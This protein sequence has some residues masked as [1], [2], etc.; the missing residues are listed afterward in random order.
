MSDSTS[1]KPLSAKTK[2]LFVQEFE[3]DLNFLNLFFLLINKS[4]PIKKIDLL[5]AQDGP[6]GRA[7]LRR[8]MGTGEALSSPCA[9]LLSEAAGGGSDPCFCELVNDFGRHEADSC[10]VSDK[11]AE[12]RVRRT[13]RAEVYRCHAGLVDIAVPVICDGEH[14]ATLLTGQVLRDLPSARG[15]VQIARDVQHLSYLNPE[16]LEKAYYRVPVVSDADIQNAI[17][18]LEVFAEYLAN[19]WS[20]LS[21]VVRDQRRAGV[22]SQLLRKEFAHA[23]LEGTVPIREELRELMHNIGLTRFPNRVLVVRLE[24][25]DEYT[26]PKPSFDVAFTAALQAVEESCDRR[27][28]RPGAV[29]IDASSGGPDLSSVAFEDASGAKVLE[30]VNSS[31]MRRRF[32]IRDGGGAADA[33]LPGLSIGTFIWNSIGVRK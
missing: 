14:I 29:R 5:W 8:L 23:V 24:S 12:Q 2:R 6:V 31:K 17:S 32:T 26:R 7:G 25:E 21:Q 19:S 28:V 18:V 9:K 3:K 27:F 10:G 1:T 22:E 15:F 16:A 33:E 11:A 4:C 30:V 13:G 20:R